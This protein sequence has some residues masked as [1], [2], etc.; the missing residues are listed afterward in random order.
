[1]AI[2]GEE[3]L[4][5]EQAILDEIIQ[6][7][8]DTREAISARTLS[9]ISRLALSPTTIRNLM[10]DLSAEGLLTTEG[11][12]RGRVPTQKAFVV[13]VTRLSEH[14][15]APSPVGP[16]VD[17]ME[18]GRLPRLPSVVGRIGRALAAETGFA[19]LAA[20]PER[21]RYPLDWASFAALP[22]RQVLVSVGTT[23]GDV[24]SKVLV[25]PE[26]FPDDLLQQV[27]RFV[28]E[29]YRGQA[30][31][32]IR[33]DVMSG[34]PKRLLQDMPSLGAAFRMLRR[35]F[36]WPDEPDRPV[37]GMEHFCSIPECQGPQQLLRIHNALTAPD[38]LMHALARARH[39]Q[40]GWVAIG[41]ETGY[42]GLENC[43]LV[44]YPFGL[45]DWQAQLA[46][47]GPMRMDYGRVFGL[48]VRS[49]EALSGY[50]H[51]MAEGSGNDGHPAH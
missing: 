26:P 13:Y 9:K 44:A 7:Y 23:F 39:I 45:G 31:E 34:E 38:F 10:E 24:W 32:A 3:I 6:Y 14:P 19:A 36:E 1:M 11:A 2:K 27:G 20:L 43:A 29:T 12:T 37:W 8:L 46:V 28:N 30:I 22:K 40:G 33:R 5:R 25:A 17:V 18:E 16:Q 48:T 4:L 35:A 41:T 21:D 49:A 50:L 42:P 47:L 51:E 15:V